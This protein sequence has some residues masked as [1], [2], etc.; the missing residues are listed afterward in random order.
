VAINP[1]RDI[2]AD[3]LTLEYGTEKLSLNV[4]KDFSLYTA[5][6]PTRAR[7]TFA[8]SVPSHKS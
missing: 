7:I 4:G 2:Q 1:R 8:I 5:Q 3:L 6:Y